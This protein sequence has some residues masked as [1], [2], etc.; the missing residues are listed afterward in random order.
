MND[1]EPTKKIDT[2]ETESGKQAESEEETG[3]KK[4]MKKSVSNITGKLTEKISDSESGQPEQDTDHDGALGD[5]E[6][7]DLGDLGEEA[8]AS[9]DE[10]ISGENVSSRVDSE[11]EI[12]MVD[13]TPDL[14]DEINQVRQE[15][16][17]ALDSEKELL[18]EEIEEAVE[19]FQDDLEAQR[20]TMEQKMDSLRESTEAELNSLKEEVESVAQGVEDLE[21]ELGQKVEQ[22]DHQIVA[23]EVDNVREEVLELRDEVDDIRD[24]VVTTEKEISTKAD[25]STAQE[26]EEMRDVMEDK[27]DYEGEE[28]GVSV[29]SQNVGEQLEKLQDRVEKLGA[30]EE[31]RDFTPADIDRDL[32]GEELEVSGDLKL[33]KQIAGN[34]LYTLEGSQGEVVVRSKRQLNEGETTIQGVV[35]E[36]DNVVFVEPL[37]S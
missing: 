1:P 20:D 3:F 11:N 14:Y 21:E 7:Q 25:Y 18:Q 15:Y 26:V 32:V 12:E 16:S 19:D 9:S 23:K 36:M 30:N 8:R 28:A 6:N 27:L 5:L 29:S 33:N 37:Y 17:Q 24:Q 4:K 10:S 31:S 35:K 13:S 2:P 34:Y 22:D